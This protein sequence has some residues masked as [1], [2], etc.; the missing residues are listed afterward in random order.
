M[1]HY[2]AIVA[3]RLRHAERFIFCEPLRPGRIGASLGTAE[4]TM[5]GVERDI[6]EKRPIF[7][8]LDELDCAVRK[9]VGRVPARG[10]GGFAVMQDSRISSEP[11]GMRAAHE[12]KELVESAGIGQ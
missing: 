9:Q 4:R 6:A 3:P 5:N 12:A 2:R 1:A 7:I 10:V 11:I 8:R